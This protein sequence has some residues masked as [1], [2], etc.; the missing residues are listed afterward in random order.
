MKRI[1]FLALSGSWLAIV[2]PAQEERYQAEI[3]AAD[4]VNS[5]GVPLK[6]LR[7][8]LRQ[9]RYNFHG[10]HHVDPGDTADPRFGTVAARTLIDG[11]RLVA[12]PG[13]EAAVIAGRVT[14]L[15]VTV[16]GARKSLVLRVVPA[17]PDGPP[18]APPGPPVI[19]M[20]GGEPTRKA[21]EPP[22]GFRLAY[23]TSLG[24]LDW[25]DSN[26]APWS[27]LRD[28]LKQD[29]ANVNRFGRADPGDE[30]DEVFNAASERTRFDRAPLRLDT[31]VA[32]PLS[33][34][35]TVKV[36]VLLTEDGTL[37]V[38]RP[39]DGAG[40]SFAATEELLEERQ[41]KV[42]GLA[43]S[44]DPE[45]AAAARELVQMAD[46]VHG[47][48]HEESALAR[49]L[50]ASLLLQADQAGEARPLLAEIE[51]DFRAAAGR[52]VSPDGIV[53]TM[54]FLIRAHRTLGDANA[55]EALLSELLESPGRERWGLDEARRGEL[56]TLRNQGA[57][58]G[59]GEGGEE[60]D[61]EEI[62][63]A[64]AEVETNP[65]APLVERLHLLVGAIS[66]HPNRRGPEYELLHRRLAERVE[67]LPTEAEDDRAALTFAEAL[68]TLAFADFRGGDF[69]AASRRCDGALALLETPARAEQLPAMT[70]RQMRVR[71]A[72]AAGNPEE[73][74]RLAKSHLDWAAERF[75][76]YDGRL[77]DLATQYFELL[78]D[79]RDAA[80][81]EAAGRPI[82]AA[83]LAETGAPG[84]HHRLACH[85]LVAELLFEA[86]APDRCDAWYGE[87]LA[88][89][90]RDPT[91]LPALGDSYSR[92]GFLY[93]GDG[94]Y[95]RAEAIW[96]EGAARLEAMPDRF[97]DYF[98]LLQDLSLVRKHY[99]D[100][101]GAVDL[102]EKSRSLAAAKLGP[103][104]REYAVA[105][106]NLVLPLNALGRS[107]QAMRMADEAIRIA[108][109]H[110]DRE[111]AR[112]SM[113]IF[114]NNRAILLMNSRPAEAAKT[115]GEIVVEM[116]K[117]GLQDTHDHALFLMNLGAAHRELGRY[118]DAEEAFLRALEIY[119]SQGW[120]D[121][122]N[123]AIV[124]DALAALALRKGRVAEAVERVRESVRLAEAFLANASAIASE[125]EKLALASLFD[126]GK[127][128]HILLAA[129]ETAE[130]CELSLRS[131]GVVLDQSIREARTLHRIA[132]DAASRET[133]AEWRVS[134][135]QLQRVSLALQHGGEGEE[136]T[137]ALVGLRQKVKRLQTLLLGGEPGSAIADPAAP[138]DLAALRAHLGEGERFYEFVAAIDERG[139][140]Y[141]GAFEITRDDLRWI[142]LATGEAARLAVVEFRESVD[143]FLG[144]RSEAEL[145][146]STGRL[147][148][149][150]RRLHELLWAPLAPPAGAG[151]RLVLCP[152]GILHFVPFAVLLD[153][154]G[155]FL[156]EDRLLDYVGS[157]R[158]FCRET[159]GTRGDLASA[160]VVGG[161][162]YEIRLSDG[163]AASSAPKPAPGGRLGEETVARSS[164]ARSGQ[165]FLAPLPGAAKEAG[166]IAG[167]LKESGAR[168]VVL[169]AGDATER[170]VAGAKGPGIVHVAT[171]GIFFNL[172]FGSLVA[173]S[174]RVD[175][176]PM[177]RGA[178][179]LAGAQASIGDWA[180]ARF[181]PSD[182]D[183]WLFAAEAAQLDLGETELVTLSAC[184]TGIGDLASGEGVIGLRRAFL[185]AGA[186]HVLSTLWPISDDMTVE[187][188]R[189]FY[190]RLGRG[191]SVTAAFGGAQGEAL[192]VFRSENAQGEAIALFGAFVMNRAGN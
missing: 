28:V 73:A 133:Y 56:E 5:R 20:P 140:A 21:P 137:P 24:P 80:G 138:V 70:A 181:P 147:E 168:V 145:S 118:D 89:T 81:I 110:P 6:S 26:G 143:A 60:L 187:L 33:R 116:E 39:G 50:L 157:A 190:E 51:R 11:A 188:M 25:V 14:T 154:T 179:A 90:R 102:I 162:D 37:L 62:L 12:S 63:A 88:A 146:A 109:S 108:A 64:L 68:L 45:A 106:N 134:Q 74:E 34:R 66:R 23:T 122:R 121:K 35:E 100:E 104:S 99:R 61:Y 153:E 67:G 79:R 91:L 131:K 156:G 151:H 142:R 159:R 124:L 75:V 96:S 43:A 117:M 119:R 36:L 92:W 16:S 69:A 141:L 18:P 22:R 2:A 130:A 78:A 97:S 48:E 129:G 175:V 55:A 172:D 93:E 163:S 127:H 77:L 83:A 192:R 176:D 165:V 58:T 126:Y 144:H 57:E 174:T 10:G 191:E 105:C 136:E 177:L 149:A 95:G 189:D 42:E 161:P 71:L 164:I 171:H 135:R 40:A 150:A 27:R 113:T 155:R 173:G 94:Q 17:D 49:V 38:S 128:V 59:P 125:P 4:R 123:L 65:S 19:P 132:S 30:R 111:W 44:R 98:S 82:A 182:N 120:E 170:A 114:R 180:E 32:G 15:E 185:A 54:G 107:E 72:L 1:A 112:P 103:A 158:D 85:G 139:D 46:L 101:Q 178:L 7:E 183:G 160:V 184:E 166:L 47:R 152:D 29:R 169:T 76:P 31:A 8:F 87:V 53:A 86:G 3:S 186:R 115:Y 52:E 9:D 167:T 148:A 41:W 84:A 13:L